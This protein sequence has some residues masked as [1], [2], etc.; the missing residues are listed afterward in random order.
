MSKL[1]LTELVLR[2]AHQSILAT[3]LRLEDML[4]IAQKLDQV[5]YWSME[6]WGGATFDACI[7]YLGEDPWDR[8]RALKKAMPN[9]KQQMLLR[10]QNLLGYRHYADD[11]VEKFVERAHKNGVDVFRIF[12]AMNDVRNLETAIKSAVKVGAHAQGTI[13]YTQSPVH[14]LDTWLTQAKQLEDLGCHSI[15]I[16]DMAGLLRPYEAE[17]LILGLKKTVDVP[18]AMQCHA[19]TGLSTATYQ[20]AIDAGIDMLDTAIS[21][22]SM[23]YG[24]SATETMVAIVEGTDRDTGLNLPLLEEI[25]SYFRDVRKK[26]AQFEGSLKGVDGRILLAQVPGGML[27]NME[28]QLKEQGAADKFDEVLLEIPKVREDLGFLPLVTPTSQIVGTQAVLNVLTK[29]RYKSITKETAGVLK[30]EYGLTPAPVNKELQA[31]VLDGEQ[32]I[33]CRPADLLKPE[34]AELETKLLAVAKEDNISL[35]DEQIDDVL[36]YALFPQIG[37]KF[38]KNKGNPDAFEPAPSLES[39]PAVLEQAPAPASGKTE[40]YSV[41]VEGKVYDVVVAPNGELKDVVSSTTQ[42]VAAPVVPVASD[43]EDLAA[44][45]SGNIFKVLVKQGHQV[46]EGEVVIILEAMKMET[47]IRAAKSGTIGEVYIS[48]GDAVSVGD[49]LLSIA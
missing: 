15:C 32:V 46:E 9:T 39:A 1:K 4:P 28:S 42:A 26:Y 20:K 21:S 16:K 35:A 8:I 40:H 37:L 41:Q 27:T 14:N 2:D 45:L 24:H 6:S 7:R 5:G 38:L 19:T 25:A 22:M 18:I 47:E 49:A 43:A 29:E 3:R 13:S 11:V 10:G 31:K 33:T 36:T 30:G 23:T 44:P 34:L 48:E 17:K 12:D